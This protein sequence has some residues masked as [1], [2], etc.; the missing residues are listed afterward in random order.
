MRYPHRPIFAAQQQTQ[1]VGGLSVTNTLIGAPQNVTTAASSTYAP[2]PVG[3]QTYNVRLS[4]QTNPVWVLF[5][6]QGVSPP[7]ASASQTVANPAVFATATQA[8]VAGQAVVIQ[9]LVPGGVVPGGFTAGKVYYVVTGG[10]TTTAAELSATPGGTAI[11]GTST[12]SV[13][14]YP[15]TT[16]TATNSVLVKATDYGEEFGIRPGQYIGTLEQTGAGALN[17]VEMTD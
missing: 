1:T 8:W 13:N 7:I 9:P 12:A 14:L 5:C 3:Q 10:L 2:L 17:I 11:Q 6:D 4:A 15:L 16:V